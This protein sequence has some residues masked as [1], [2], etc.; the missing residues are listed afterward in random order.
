MSRV[1]KAVHEYTKNV[2]KLFTRLLVLIKF[3]IYGVEDVSLYAY[4]SFSQT[5][6]FLRQVFIKLKLIPKKCLTGDKRDFYQ[7]CYLASYM[8]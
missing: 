1:I 5:K 8:L 6:Y 3:T 4:H 2:S 7:A